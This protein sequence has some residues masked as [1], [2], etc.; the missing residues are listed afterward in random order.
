MDK[1]VITRFREAIK[2]Q[3]VPPYLQLQP[4]FDAKAEGKSDRV[5]AGL[6]EIPYWQ[7]KAM[8]EL[9]AQGHPTWEPVYKCWERK[10]AES[11]G[12]IEVS[13]FGRALAGNHKDEEDILIREDA[14]TYESIMRPQVA[15]GG[16]KGLPGGVQVNFVKFSEADEPPVLEGEFQTEEA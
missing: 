6:A 8:L 15:S 7:L 5:A 11:R 1:G 9:G 2:A 16:V 13:K 14:E 12:Q 3:Q 4:A 10:K